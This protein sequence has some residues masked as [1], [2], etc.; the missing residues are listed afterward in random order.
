METVRIGDQVECSIVITTYD[1]PESLRLVLDSI[2]SQE[3]PFSYEVI[4]VK[5]GPSN[6]TL[7]VCEDFDCIVLDSESTKY[8]NP[9]RA[10]NIGYRASKGEILISQ[11]DDVKYTDK[12]SISRLVLELCPG[13]FLLTRTENWQY[14]GSHPARCI[15]D[16]CSIDKRPVPFFFCGAIL[17]KDVYAIGGNDEEFVEVD[18]DDNWF[19]DCITKGLGLKPRYSS[20]IV[21][22]HIAHGYPAERQNNKVSHQLYLNKVREANR[23]GIWQSSGGPWLYD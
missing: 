8:G 21:T 7:R 18:Y 23:T 22:H 1:K 20:D 15:G 4:V 16:Y 2:F 10:R 12:N 19:A 14:I 11:C 3:I 17:R 9:A 5:D 6:S 13:E